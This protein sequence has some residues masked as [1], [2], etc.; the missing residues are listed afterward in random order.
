ME[1]VTI[2]GERFNIKM[3][4]QDFVQF[5]MKKLFSLNAISDSELELLQDK[6][7]CKIKFNLNYPLL[8]KDKEAFASD[9]KHVRYY[10]KETFFEEGFYLCNHW[11]PEQNEEPFAKW[12]EELASNA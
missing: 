1:S 8:S 7:Y 6:D 12:L 9:I 2:N 3:N 4:L 10:A 5:T 11:F